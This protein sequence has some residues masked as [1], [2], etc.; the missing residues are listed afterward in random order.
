MRRR[1]L[2]VALLAVLVGSAVLGA[3]AGVALGSILWV[4]TLIGVLVP[5]T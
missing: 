2:V 1:Y 5:A 3:L 4:V